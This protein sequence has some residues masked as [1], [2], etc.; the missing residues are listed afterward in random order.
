ML[1]RSKT[2]DVVDAAVVVLAV[3]VAAEIVTADRRDIALLLD[4]ARVSL[5]IVDA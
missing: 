3:D 1:A 5:R 4:A 2:S